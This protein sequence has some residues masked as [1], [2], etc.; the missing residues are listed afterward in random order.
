MAYDTSIS[1]PWYMSTYDLPS[2]GML[3]NIQRTAV[4][5]YNRNSIIGYNT[6]SNCSSACRTF[7]LP[8][9]NYSIVFIQ[10]IRNVSIFNMY[11]Y[12]KI[13][14]IN[15][16]IDNLSK[17]LG[18]NTYSY[19]S[20]PTSLPAS[21]DASLKQSIP[22]IPS[23]DALLDSYFW[24][25]LDGDVFCTKFT[26][27]KEVLKDACVL[28]LI[29]TPEDVE[30]LSMFPGIIVRDASDETFRFIQSNVLSGSNIF[31]I[32]H[33]EGQLI[34]Y[35]LETYYRNLGSDWWPTFNSR[36]K[37]LKMKETDL[38]ECPYSECSDFMN[39]K[40]MYTVEPTY[41]Q[42]INPDERVYQI[43][44]QMSDDLVATAYKKSNFF[45][46]IRNNKKKMSIK[47]FIEYLS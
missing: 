8:A 23:D 45:I 29:G 47:N 5:G 18:G 6:N 15:N 34:R 32:L 38:Y 3:P 28:H 26:I 30:E 11:I 13:H 19:E 17:H 2:P 12:K 44:I 7:T 37:E 16:S 4:T 43:C 33:A 14:K 1:L 27:E 21:Y 36:N 20:L 41:T 42:Q 35:K 9:P 25:Y 10:H 40:H 31:G 39:P 24:P 46:S 22:L